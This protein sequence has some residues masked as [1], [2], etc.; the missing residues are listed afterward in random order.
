MNLL[1]FSLVLISPLEVTG[2]G[3]LGWQDLLQMAGKIPQTLRT[4]SMQYNG[5]SDEMPLPRIQSS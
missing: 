3:F 4:L 1:H 2:G 5:P